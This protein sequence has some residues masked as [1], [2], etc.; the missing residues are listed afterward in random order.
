MYVCIDIECNSV[1]SFCLKVRWFPGRIW[2][3]RGKLVRKYVFSL[4]RYGVLGEN[5]RKCKS[6]ILFS[7]MHIY[8]IPPISQIRSKRT[9]SRPPSPLAK[10]VAQRGRR[11]LSAFSSR[12]R[13]GT[14]RAT[15]KLPASVGQG[16]HIGR[17]LSLRAHILAA[18]IIRR[19]A[20]GR[21]QQAART[22]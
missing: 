1:L 17:Y 21:T 14:A 19:R 22:R 15:G 9:R 5:I 3:G 8:I 16:A 6:E 10:A 11:S 2:L 18:V 4:K 13:R 12:L 20:P 7:N